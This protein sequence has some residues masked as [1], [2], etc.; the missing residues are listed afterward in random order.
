M[1]VLAQ[2]RRHPTRLWRGYT[3]LVARNLPFTGLQFPLF[4]HLRSKMVDWRKTQKQRKGEKT[5]AVEEGILERAVITAISAGLAGSVAAVITTPIDV[6]KTRIML[7]A[8]ESD[9]NNNESQSRRIRKRPGA[10]AVGRDIYL[11]EGLKGL[12]RGGILRGVWTALGLGLYLS[13]YESGR[14]YL[15]NR[16]KN[17]TQSSQSGNLGFKNKSEEGEAV[18]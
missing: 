1:K 16:R 11:Q 18:I 17:K 9:N 8:G 7:A 3:A 6:V 5:D 15:E 12:F 4:E 13:A 10:L 14:V 2:F